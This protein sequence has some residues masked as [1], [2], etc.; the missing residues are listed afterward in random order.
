[1]SIINEPPKTIK[2]REYRWHFP[3]SP[4]APGVSFIF[5]QHQYF[6]KNALILCTQY[7][8]LNISMRCASF[9][10]LSGKPPVCFLTTRR[11]I[12]ANCCCA[13]SGAGRCV[14]C[15]IIVIMEKSCRGIFENERV[16]VRPNERNREKPMTLTHPPGCCMRFCPKPSSDFYKFIKLWPQIIREWKK[17]SE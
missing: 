1:M 2:R 17:K 11:V 10:K 3:C 4:I 16:V 13:R 6:S 7:V 5:L 8:C 12:T 15:G 14:V 9:K